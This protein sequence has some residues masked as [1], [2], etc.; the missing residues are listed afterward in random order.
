MIFTIT[1]IITAKITATRV[2]RRGLSLLFHRPRTSLLISISTLLLCLTPSGVSCNMNSK[3]Q[4]RHTP[5]NNAPTNSEGEWL[6]KRKERRGGK[7]RPKSSFAGQLYDCS[8]FGIAQIYIYLCPQ[9]NSSSLPQRGCLA[10]QG[11]S[12]W[13]RLR[14]G[15]TAEGLM[16][17]RMLC[18]MSQSV[19][20]EGR[21]VPGTFALLS[22]L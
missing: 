21:R 12:R 1:R 4:T 17:Q 18:T 2:K 15:V 5:L 11:A 13:M 16:T 3:C 19:G 14:V 10:T 9:T 22:G 7:V 6:I 20:L 8:M